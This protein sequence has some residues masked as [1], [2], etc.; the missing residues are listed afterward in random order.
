[1]CACNSSVNKHADNGSRFLGV[2]GAMGVVDPLVKMSRT[3]CLFTGPYSLSLYLSY[4]WLADLTRSFS[5]VGE[6]ETGSPLSADKIG[7]K[8]V[9]R[10]R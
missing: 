8:M 2:M 4:A 5:V 7:S 6:I 3:R 1:M 9:D 10:V